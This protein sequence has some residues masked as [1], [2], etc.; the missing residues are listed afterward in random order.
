M[1]ALTDDGGLWSYEAGALVRRATL[2]GAR[3][4][5]IS[6]DGRIAIAAGAGLPNVG[7]TVYGLDEIGA[8]HL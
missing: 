4:I 1:L 3:A 6:P 2:A 5:A 7:R 8:G